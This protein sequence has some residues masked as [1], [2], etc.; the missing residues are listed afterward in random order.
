MHRCLGVRQ[1]GEPIA[2]DTVVGHSPPGAPVHASD[3]LERRACSVWAGRPRATPARKQAGTHK[4]QGTAGRVHQRQPCEPE[5]HHRSG[6][7]HG[8]DAPADP[9]FD[10]LLPFTGAAAD[11]RTR[12]ARRPARAE[13]PASRTGQDRRHRDVLELQPTVRH[14]LP[15]GHTDQAPRGGRPLPP[16]AEQSRSGAD[17]ALPRSE[18][19][20]RRA[21]RGLGHRRAAARIPLRQRDGRR[22]RLPDEPAPTNGS[23]PCRAATKAAA[24]ASS[25]RW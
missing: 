13:Q 8:H 16:D 7:P 10:L 6:A 11:R 22:L 19:A 15:G 3:H 14:A 4:E 9:G 24:A 18:V 12:P 2:T 1:T 20:R 21:R 5:Q 25:R 23:R 17:P